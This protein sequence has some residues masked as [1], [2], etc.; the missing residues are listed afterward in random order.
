[1]ADV[2]SSYSTIQIFAEDN[3]TVN[4]MGQ[5]INYNQIGSYNY[6]VKTTSLTNPDCDLVRRVAVYVYDKAECEYRFVQRMANHESSGTVT[7]LGIPLGGTSE[8][9]R[10]IDA[11]LSTHG[12][13]FNV[14][15]LL[16]IGTTWQK[17]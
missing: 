9:N 6:F 14:V 15:S 12:S 10:A 17:L 3:P 7:L 4:L 11:D 5:T 8:S 2:T 1:N 16:G 13:V